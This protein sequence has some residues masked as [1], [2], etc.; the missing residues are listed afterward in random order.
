MTD[1]TISMARYMLRNHGLGTFLKSIS[2]FVYRKLRRMSIDLSK[3]HTLVINGYKMSVM[4]NDEGISASL[5]MFKTHEPLTTG[6]LSRTIK[7]GM[8]CVDVGSNIGYYALLEGKIVGDGGQVFAIE[9]SPVNFALLNENISLQNHDNTRAYNFAAGDHN[10]NV[11][12]MIDKKSN[13][14]KVVDTEDTSENIID[15]KSRTLDDFVAEQSIKKIDLLRMDVEGYEASILDG[16]KEIIRKFKPIIAIE[17]H[18]RLLGDEKTRKIFQNFVNMHYEIKHFSPRE[19]DVPMVG[20][21][22]DTKPISI[23]EVLKKIDNNS[24]PAVF[25]IIIQVGDK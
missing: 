3:K 7:P 20:S 14:C 15:V 4:P 17:I 12:F 25:N 10:G 19:L 11:K 13:W 18:Q 5:L 2:F 8:Y 23:K 1:S 24:L 21:I 16:A 22:N 6:L 9:P